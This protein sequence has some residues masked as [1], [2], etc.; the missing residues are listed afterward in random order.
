MHNTL[1]YSTKIR[2]KNGGFELHKGMDQFTNSFIFP[3]FEQAA[4]IYN[5]YASSAIFP[6]I[7]F[8]WLYL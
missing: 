6:S 5:W 8:D 7:K 1:K 4:L 2:C 3:L